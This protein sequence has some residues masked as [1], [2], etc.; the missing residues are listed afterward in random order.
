MAIR[1]KRQIEERDNW[2]AEEL[3]R[4]ERVSAF[5]LDGKKVVSEKELQDRAKKKEN[6]VEGLFLFDF[7]L[8]IGLAFINMQLGNGVSQP[9]IFLIMMIFFGLLFWLFIFHRVMPAWFLILIALIAIYMEYMA[10]CR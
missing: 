1:N 3:K 5:D 2:L 8:A 9:T 4:E 6:A 7:F 10:I